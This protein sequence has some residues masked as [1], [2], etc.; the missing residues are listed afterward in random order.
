MW[1]QHLV[2]APFGVGLLSQILE[3]WDVRHSFSVFVKYASKILNFSTVSTFN[4][5]SKT[6]VREVSIRCET[7]GSIAGSGMFP[8]CRCVSSSLSAFGAIVFL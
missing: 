1:T 8:V 2:H 6:S 4:L 3:V 7:A 5:G